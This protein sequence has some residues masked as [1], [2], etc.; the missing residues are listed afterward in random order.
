LQR[1]RFKEAVDE[2]EKAHRFDPANKVIGNNL[3]VAYNNYAVRLM[4]DKHF[5]EARQYLEKAS[6]ISSEDQAVKGNLSLALS[7]TGGDSASTGKMVESG[8]LEG[9][10][11]LHKIADDFL[12]QGI[13][14]FEKKEYDLAK[15]VLQESIKFSKDNSMAYEILGDMAYLQQNLKGAREYYT[16]AFGLKRTKT[17]EEK[18]EKLTREAPVEEKLDLYADEHFIIRYKERIQDQFGGGFEIRE[19]LRQAY[20]AISQDFGF[21]PTDKVAVLLYTEEEY[22]ELSKT[23]VWTAGHFDGKIRLPAYEKKIHVRELNKLIWHELTHFFVQNLSQSRCPTWL[24]EGLAQY[25]E[26]KVKPINLTYFRVAV[27]KKYLLSMDELG[28]G[29]AENQDATEVLLFYQQ[30]FVITKHL[31]DRY[32]MFKI[33]QMLTEF[34][35]GKTTDEVFKE[36]LGVSPR[37]FEIKW[38]ASLDEKE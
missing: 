5:L 3:A 17:L 22:R 12:M 37:A 15:D 26:N 30:S 33:K 36:V 16:R 7:K 21:Y 38:L 6:V 32:R 8:S 11:A 35:K 27:N 19:Y 1:G 31:V 20:K 34:G 24:N 13:Q 18:L 2:F 4:E 14:Y 29:I 10:D 23:P 28:K 25:E 9:Q